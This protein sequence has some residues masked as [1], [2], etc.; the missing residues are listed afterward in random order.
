MS[1]VLRMTGSRTSSA[2]YP[3]SPTADDIVAGSIASTAFIA[4]TVEAHFDGFMDTRAAIPEIR[5]AHLFP[6]YLNTLPRKFS[7][8]VF[9]P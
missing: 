6:D 5:S 1:A 2:P 9:V 3:C 4:A 8:F 7:D